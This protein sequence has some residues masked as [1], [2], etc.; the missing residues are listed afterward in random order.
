MC[1]FVGVIL[2]CILFAILAEATR[3]L[4]VSVMGGRPAGGLAYKLSPNAASE[5]PKACQ[6]LG[7]THF[8]K[9]KAGG[10]HIDALFESYSS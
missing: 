4:F 10:K 7:L 1:F 8:R 5:L 2:V 3:F 6:P 9:K